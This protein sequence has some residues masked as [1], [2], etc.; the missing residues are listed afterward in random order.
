MPCFSIH[1]AVANE[2]LKKN[3]IADKDAFIKGIMDVDNLPDT[4]KCHY[5]S[6]NN[7][8]SNLK[9]YLSNKVNINKYLETN[10]LKTDYDKGY[11]LHLLT[12]YHFYTS[13]TFFSNEF[14]SNLTVDKFKEIIYQDYPT[15]NDHIKN[16][17]NVTYPDEV[18][19][20]DISSS[21]E[22]NILNIDKVDDFINKISSIDLNSYI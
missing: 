7:D 13:K 3:I 18:K 4:Y 6:H 19:K 17:Y 10:T 5:S 12:D 16:K 9:H 2:Y 20:W 11:F 15:I 8:K 1:L 14:L 22:P 21:C